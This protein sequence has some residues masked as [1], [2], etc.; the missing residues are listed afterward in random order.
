MD[1]AT[2]WAII[3][4]GGKRALSDPDRQ[5]ASVR[6]RLAKLPP[7]Q[8]REFHRHVWRKLADAHSWDLWG[9][10]YLINGGCSDDGFL[11]FCAWLVSRGRAVYEA[12]VANPDSL[13][14]LTDTDRDDY[15][16]EDLLSV[17][18]DAYEDA[19]SEEMVKLDLPWP[20]K[21]RGR[22][23]DFDDDDKV[24]RRLPELANIYFADR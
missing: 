17:A 20:K 23:W 24:A 6:K 19:T 18:F 11:Y 5:L 3:E 1:D 16:F 15:E 7:E 12:A 2:F 10:A 21:P 22:R 14:G 13:A 4:S 8:I 9:A